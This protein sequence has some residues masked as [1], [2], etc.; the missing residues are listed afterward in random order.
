MKSRKRKIWLF[1]LLMLCLGM[2]GC[3]KQE[4]KEW[5]TLA[6][7]ESK[8][9]IHHM[10]LQWFG[11]APDCTHGGYQM[12]ICT[13]CGWVDQSACGE[14]MAL[15]HTPAIIIQQQGNCREDT[16]IVYKCTVCGEQIGYE[17]HTESDGH[18]W[19]TGETT[20]WD[21]RVMDFVT[22]QIWYCELC[23]MQGAEEE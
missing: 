20:F 9:H 10:S 21:E 13:I 8:E 23:G 7:E 18:R 1:G 6:E 12:A 17:R 19:M 14:V 15:A 22:Q 16:V 11:E 2:S 3:I 4:K 5:E